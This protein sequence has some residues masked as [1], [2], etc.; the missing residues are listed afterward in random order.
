MK[1]IRLF[2]ILSMISSAYGCSLIGGETSERRTM[3][4]DSLIVPNQ[5]ASGQAFPI[6]IVG[7][8]TS[9]CQR[10]E[11]IEADRT[12]GQLTLRMIAR[13]QIRSSAVCTTDIRFVGQD[14]TVRPPFS[15]PFE[16]VALQPDESEMRRTVRVQ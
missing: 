6:R 8:L 1:S 15:D 14:Y 5:V 3:P 10:F 4:L 16:I 7:M 2:V 13:E 9:G 12:T 11:R